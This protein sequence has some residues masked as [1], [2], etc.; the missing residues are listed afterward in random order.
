MY[1]YT[2]RFTTVKNWLYYWIFL[3]IT[4]VGKSKTCRVG[5]Q[6]G[7][8]GNL[9]SSNPKAVCWQNPFFLEGCVF[10]SC[11]HFQFFA[12]S[13]T[14]VPRLPCSPLTPEVCSNSRQYIE[15]AMLSN[16]LILCHPLLPLP[17]IF[18]SIRVSS[19]KLALSIRWPKYWYFSFSTSPSNEYSGLTSF[20]IDCSDLLAVKGTIKSLLQHHNWKG[21]VLWY[22][23]RQWQTFFSWAPKSLQMVTAAMK[24]KLLFGRKAMTNQKAET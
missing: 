11:C 24:L 2:L 22:K 21:S 13:W 19:K 4:E 16:H 6:R 5:M 14:A 1:T 23:G 3:R 17:S 15:S 10:F 18:P 9:I 7:G 20:M 8:P 12:T